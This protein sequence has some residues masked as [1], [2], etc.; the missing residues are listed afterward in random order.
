M[1]RLANATSPYLLQHKDNPVAWWEWGNEAFAEAARTGKPVLLSI[2][3]AAC[4][5]CH[6]MAHESFENDSIAALM[7]ELFI[8]IKVDREERP[9]VDQVYMAALHTLGEQGGW[10]LTMFLTDQRQAFWGGTYFPPVPRYGKASF[11]QILQEIARLYREERNRID[12]NAGAIRDAL[13][14]NFAVPVVPETTID[15]GRIAATLAA[16][17][18]TEFGGLQG[19]PKFPN[20]P[21]LAVL[22]RDGIA[23]QQSPSWQA[24]LTTLDGMIAGGIHDHI[25]G[26]FSR[27]AV[28]EQWLVPHFEKML[29]DNAQILELLAEAY[30]LTG[31]DHYRRAAEGIVVWLEREMLMPEGGFASSLD[32]DSEGEEGKFYVWTRAEL[33]THF[34][35]SE[36]NLLSDA[37]DIHPGGNWEG[38][39]IPNRIGKPTL[40]DEEDTALA[41]LR[42]R[43]LRVRMK[44][45]PPGRDDK[46]LA[47]WN[48]MMI[49]ALA[50]ASRVFARPD[51]LTLA[52]RAF[53]FI[54]RTMDRDGQLG[55][56]W[57]EGRLLFPGF[58]SDHAAMALAALSLHEAG[59]CQ[60]NLIHKSI[61]WVNTCCAHYRTADG[62]LAL[63]QAGTDL[64]VPASS[65]RDDAI[66]NP[67]GIMIEVLIRL[68]ALTGDPTHLDRADELLARGLAAASQAPLGHGSIVSGLMMRASAVTIAIAGT[69]PTPLMMVAREI[70]PM[71]TILVPPG[72]TQPGPV[73]QAQWNEA[74]EGAAFLCVGS[75]CTLPLHEAAHLKAEWQTLIAT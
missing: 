1:N 23:D 29:Y 55:H 15:P 68:H 38:H 8:C 42:D 47:D 6:V 3:Y 70:S 52:E 60:E 58:A 57:R 34:T 66:Q 37:Y 2:G 25:G 74:G 30:A 35:T 50:R 45:I 72:T 26:G 31:A 13:I 65:T 40:S 19:A 18:D 43:L 59:S 56:S 44:R 27:Y 28:D 39:A 51:W 16:A 12:E 24:F 75:R 7:N 64:P 53:D 61:Q 4:H 63:A 11:P 14:Q 21:L 73:D 69:N 54:A 5:W 62:L 46:V 67:N 9:D 22:L 49:A 17:T 33:D 41:P 10:P 36:A 32:A 48:G 71:T 20:A